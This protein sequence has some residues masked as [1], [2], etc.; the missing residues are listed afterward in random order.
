LNDCGQPVAWTCSCAAGRA[1]CH[2]V[3]ALVYQLQHY[4]KLDL[5]VVPPVLSKTS[6]PQVSSFIQAY[7]QC[8]S[9]SCFLTQHYVF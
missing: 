9:G 1:M 3:V 2:H 6:L 5:H 4:Q 8:Q 7:I